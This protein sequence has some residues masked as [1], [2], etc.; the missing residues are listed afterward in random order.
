M[1]RLERAFGADADIGGLFAAELGQIH[2][3]LG[4]VQ[5]R[6]AGISPGR[7]VAASDA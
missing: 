1:L 4:E 3:D 2:A 5:A 7:R 6:A